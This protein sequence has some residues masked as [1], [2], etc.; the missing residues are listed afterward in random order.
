[1]NPTASLLSQPTETR[2]L[3]ALPVFCLQRCWLLYPYQK[4][5]VHTQFINSILFPFPLVN[6]HFIGLV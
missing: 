6:H 1:M 3:G 2:L 5:E 4:Y